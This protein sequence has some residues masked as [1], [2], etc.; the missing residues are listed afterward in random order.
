MSRIWYLIAVFV[1][2]GGVAVSGWVVWTG[3]SGLSSALVRV[4]VP[5]EAALVLDNPGEYT[6]FHETESVIDGRVYSSP[7]IAGLRVKV[8]SETTGAPLPLA[9]PTTRQTYQL[10]GH[11]GVSIFSLSVAEPGRYRLSGSYGDGRSEPKTV[12]AV[13][14]GFVA[15]L[16]QL[17]FI[18]LVA[19]LAGIGGGAALAVVTFVKRRRAAARL[20]GA[21]R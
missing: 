1:L 19:A 17:V 14:R 12:L 21:W 18:A 6:I 10:S 11:S 4:V 8:A 13:G 15:R 7:S 3:L 5:G 2:L 9:T 16:L 20:A